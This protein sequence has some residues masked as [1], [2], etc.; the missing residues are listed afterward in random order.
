M[1]PES[2]ARGLTV[3]AASMHGLLQPPCNHY[4]KLLAPAKAEIKGSEF[5]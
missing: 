1:E 2:Q 3:I 5:W 4:H